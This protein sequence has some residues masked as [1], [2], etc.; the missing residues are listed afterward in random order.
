MSDMLKRYEETKAPRPSEAKKY[1][2]LEV[3]FF[4]QQSVY[5]VGFTTKEVK[6]NPTRFTDKALNYFDYQLSHISVPPSFQS[7]EQGVELSQWSAKKPYY[8]AGKGK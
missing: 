5:Q 6:G 4:D 2:D 8:D 7:I 1:P 3:N